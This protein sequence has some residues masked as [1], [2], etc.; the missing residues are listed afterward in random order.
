VPAHSMTSINGAGVSALPS[1][2]PARPTPTA[3]RLRPFEKAR[4]DF[5]AAW[6]NNLPRGSDADFPKNRRQRAATAWKDRMHDTG[7]GLPTSVASGRSNYFC[8]AGLTI[9]TVDAHI[10]Q[11]HLDMA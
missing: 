9:D 7:L 6:R 5:D 1:R 3:A 11:D 10:E 4:T 8:G 2:P